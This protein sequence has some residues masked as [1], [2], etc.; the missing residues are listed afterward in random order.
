MSNVTLK[1]I[2]DIEYQPVQPANE[3]CRVRHAGKALGVTGLGMSI[4]EMESGC[5]TAAEQPHLSHGRE[6]VYVILRGSATLE[7]SAGAL[8]LGT[9]ALVRVGSGERRRFL[10]G[11][12]GVTLLA[13]G[14]AP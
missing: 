9:G 12:D 4:L 2:E 5:A 14:A 7:T 8:L 6:E 1:K 13:L 11:P 10:P 3:G